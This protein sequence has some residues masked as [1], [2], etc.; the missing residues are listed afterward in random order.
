MSQINPTDS[1]AH[2]K[3][4]CQYHVV[5]APKYR[6][7]VILEQKRE[8]GAILRESCKWKKVCIITEVLLFCN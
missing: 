8:I 7:Q 5:F 4:R 6:R 1:L 2:S 3:W